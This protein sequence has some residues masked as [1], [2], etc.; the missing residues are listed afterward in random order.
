MTQIAVYGLWHLGTV[1]AACLASKG[2]D[3]IG[4]D[5]NSQVAGALMRGH[6]PLFEPGLEE[7]V[8]KGVASRLLNFTADKKRIENADIIW[9]TLDTPVDDQDEADSAQ[10]MAKVESLF[11]HIKEGAVILVS[12]QLPA[13]STQALSK[14][15]KAQSD[16]KVSFAYSPENLR[17]GKAIKVF[18]EPER[19]I[20]GVENE[21]ARSVLEPVLSQL[22]DNLLWMRVESAEMVKH[23]LN[24]FLAICITFINEIASLCE[25]LGADASEV[26]WG[27]RSEPRIGQK[28]YIKPGGAFAG[29]TL[30]RDV[31]Y[32]KHIA[33]TG[34]VD[35]PLLSHIIESNEVHKRWIGRM[36]T[37]S[38]GALKG[39][40]IAVLGLAYTPGTNTLRRSFAV[41]FCQWLQAQGAIISAYDPN[42]ESLPPELDYISLAHDILDVCQ[43]ADA[44]V[45]AN[46]HPQFKELTSAAVLDRMRNPLVIDQN[47]WMSDLYQSNRI[48]CIRLGAAA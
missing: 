47:G 39:K 32:L 36:L 26:E 8:K 7:L 4:L 17:L 14:Q 13:G 20:I 41:E 28:A 46:E 38:L 43:D 27:L 24:G 19:I 3:V 21:H 5:D 40:N 10:V 44:L 9:V 42:I 1:T 11:P 30:A 33:A 29:G 48:T 23:A 35:I 22:S 18:L 16:K 25:T 34:G 45:V 2:F 15:F 12:S 37:K 6:P 31:N